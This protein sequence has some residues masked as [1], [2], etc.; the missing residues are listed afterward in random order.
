MPD[1]DL[2]VVFSS[3][4][5]QGEYPHQNLLEDYILASILDNT[6]TATGFDSFVSILL[7]SIAVP[8]VVV[9]FY[10]FYKTRKQ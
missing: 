6:S 7:V 9:I 10:W 2:L 1:E 5:R 8:V 4:V 3:N